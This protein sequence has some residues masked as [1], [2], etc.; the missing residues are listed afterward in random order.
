MILAANIQK[1]RKKNGLTQEELAEKLG[2]TFQAVSKWENAKSAPDILFLPQMADLFECHIDELFSR[3]IT[4]EIH[5]DHCTALPWDDDDTIRVL[6]TKGKKIL[7]VQERDLCMEVSFPKN[8][9]ETSK[10][11][12]KVEV[13]GNM[14]CDS[15]INGDVICHGSLDCHEI[16]GNVN[17][18]GDI[19]AYVINSVSGSVSGGTS[20]AQKEDNSVSEYMQPIRYDKI[21]VGSRCFDAAY[22]GEMDMTS[23]SDYARKREYWRIEEPGDVFAGCAKTGD[24]LPYNNYPYLEF[25]LG[26]VFVIDYHKRDGTVDRLYYIADGTVWQNMLCTKRILVDL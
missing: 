2:V 21:T 10:Q 12:F 15:S 14:F 6:Q 1:Y 7:K 23:W 11:Y 9:N 25:Q 20:K 13:L 5:Y 8:C 26:Q 19:H 3:E 17:T 18:D 16:N 22:F 24:V 4:T